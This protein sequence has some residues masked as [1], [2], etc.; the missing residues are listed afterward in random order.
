MHDI[1]LD[2]RSWTDVM[3]FYHALL[4]A[5]GAP[6]WHGTSIDALV[7]SM[8]WGEINAVEPPYRIQIFN[9]GS[10][11]SEAIREISNSRVALLEARREFLARRG[12]DVEVSLEIES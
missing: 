6:N 2:A 1:K 4:L 5:L 8:V 11:P 9:T 12:K 10:L 3:D 7:D